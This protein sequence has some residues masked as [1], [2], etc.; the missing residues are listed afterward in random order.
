LRD[1]CGIR[2]PAHFTVIMQKIVTR[3]AGSD[4]FLHDH[5]HKE[6][7]GPQ[8]GAAQKQLGPAEAGPSW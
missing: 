5:R 2:P 4:D 7:G 3:L 1:P 6:V 8:G